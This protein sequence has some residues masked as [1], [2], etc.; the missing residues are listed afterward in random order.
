M[1]FYTGQTIMYIISTR[2]QILDK[3]V[4]ISLHAITLR[5]DINLSLFPPIMGK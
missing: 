4:C 1:Q 2:V 5:K 3:A